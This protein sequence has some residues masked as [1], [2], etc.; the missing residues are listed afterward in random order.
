[1]DRS[2]SS[3]LRRRRADFHGAGR[4]T[5]YR[6]PTKFHQ[7]TSIDASVIHRAPVIQSSHALSFLPASLRTITRYGQ[8]PTVQSSGQRRRV[9]GKTKASRMKRTVQMVD[10]ACQCSIHVA[11][12]DSCCQAGSGATSH[13]N[14]AVGT[15]HQ[16]YHDAAV[17]TTR[18]ERM[19]RMTE[20]DVRLVDVPEIDYITSKLTLNDQMEELNSS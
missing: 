15:P 8:E 6:Y 4:F 3:L 9:G 17:M 1:M 11:M 19:S 2:T 20:T 7:T 12:T 14:R 10:T 5:R 18:L 16:T 13:V